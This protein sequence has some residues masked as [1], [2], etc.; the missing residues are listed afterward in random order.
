MLINGREVPVKEWHEE[1]DQ[2][3][4][5]VWVND[6]EVCANHLNVSRPGGCQR[7][8]PAPPDTP[9]TQPRTAGPG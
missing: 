2:E 5:W 3:G 6:D 7:E 9:S 4:E 8:N 1:C